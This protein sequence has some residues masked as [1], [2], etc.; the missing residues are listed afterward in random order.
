MVGTRIHPNLSLTKLKQSYVRTDGIIE[1]Q[2]VLNNEVRLMQDLLPK[3]HYSRWVFVVGT[4][5]G[6]FHVQCLFALWFQRCV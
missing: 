6:L 3:S 4:I 5:W 2:E 1:A